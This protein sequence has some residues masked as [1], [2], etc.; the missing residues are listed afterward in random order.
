MENENISKGEQ[1]RQQIIEAAMH[2]FLKQGFHGTSMREIA[3]NAHI[4]LGGIYNHFG[5]KE[6][7]FEAVFATY[8]PYNH[9]V[10]AVINASGDSIEEVLNNVARTIIEGL[11][12]NPDFLNLLFIDLVEFQRAN[13][14]KLLKQQLPV[15]QVVYE[16]LSKLNASSN[17]GSQMR[18]IP[19]LIV[20]RS[21]FGLFFS[22]YFTDRIISGDSGV[23]A[24]ISENAF[25][26][27]V[28]IYL[29]G[30]LISDQQ[31]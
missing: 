26:Y 11:K 13:T 8:H 3:K 24:E 25:D 2:L 27:F 23:P 9:V 15:F 6:A 30:L 4:A 14:V 7:I 20:A 1:T 10:P 17:N 31:Q 29:H 5:T 12:K 16:R 28:D 22:Y 19:P 21:F 18:P